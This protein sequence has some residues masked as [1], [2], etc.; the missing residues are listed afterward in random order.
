MNQFCKHFYTIQM[1]DKLIIR[2][3]DLSKDILS[4]RSIQL[5]GKFPNRR[6]PPTDVCFL[7]NEEQPECPLYE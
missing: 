3:C 4:Q 1:D 5:V 6:F 7:E 2:K